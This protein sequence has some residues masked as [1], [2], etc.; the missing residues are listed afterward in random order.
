M[1]TGS[2]ITVNLFGED[3][4]TLQQA[5]GNMAGALRRVEGVAEVDDGLEDAQTAYHVSV[6]RNAAM[7][8]GYTVAQI[9]MDIATALTSSATAMDMDMDSVTADVVVQN[10][11]GMSLADL[12]AYT[13]ESTNQMTG[14]TTSFRLDEVATV[15]PTVSMSSIS[16][17]DQRRYMSVTALL[18]P[19]YN[20][21]LVTDEAQQ[22]MEELTLPEGVSYEFAGENETIMDAVEDLMLMLLIGVI[23]V[24]FIMVA[25]FQSLK[26]PFIVMFTIPL[27]FTGG[28]AAL[29]VCHMDVSIVSIIGF[30][31]LVGIIVNNG[32]VLV[33]YV[34]QLRANGME[35]REALVEAGVTR[36]RPIF[37]TSLTTI[38]GL[39]VMAMGQ[40]VGTSLMQPVAVVCIGGLLYATIMTLFVVP[41]IYDILNR[42]ELKVI[43]DE[44]MQFEDHDIV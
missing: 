21:T 37:M 13:F 15:E 2:G 14:E 1:L 4:Q 36:M 32:I 38:L 39:I 25:Q 9:Y 19:G 27:A 11:D 33:D 8:K 5:A 24:Y 35:R 43:T 22:A 3:M 17:I 20:V 16:R 23:L 44:D 28:F 41:C 10:E 7:Q 40:N 42:R 31:M 26:S 34:N 29:L 6:D 18:E 30:V 12:K